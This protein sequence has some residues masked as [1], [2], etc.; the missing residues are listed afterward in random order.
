M[1]QVKLSACK[2]VLKID[3]DGKAYYHH[4]NTLIPVYDAMNNNKQF[5][6][7]SEHW[8]GM[9]C[10]YKEGVLTRWHKN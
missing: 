3:I 1:K 10:T 8:W 7:I 5:E 9:S 4:N 2:S 6:A